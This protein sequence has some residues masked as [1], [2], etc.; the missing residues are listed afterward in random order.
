M[1]N[2]KTYIKFK[3]S[4]AKRLLEVLKEKGYG[5]TI[6]RGLHPIDVPRLAREIECTE[7]VTKRYLS[8]TA[9][10][11]FDTLDKLAALLD[12]DP[13]W[14]YCGNAQN[15]TSEQDIN[16][17]KMVL[18]KLMKNVFNDIEK[19][20]LEEA[21]NFGF[22]VHKQIAPLSNIPEEEKHRLI[23]WLTESMQQELSKI[24]TIQLKH[25]IKKERL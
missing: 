21:L 17:L 25:K 4:F 3:N 24:S 11:T 12:V 22:E 7:I 23:D 6:N 13:L 10:P 15:S 5:Q 2:N 8:G 20:E 18:L 1:S 19:K 9:I 14:L 16:L